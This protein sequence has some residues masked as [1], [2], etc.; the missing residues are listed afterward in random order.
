MR[1]WL[2]PADNNLQLALPGPYF[3]VGVIEFNRCYPLAFSSICW[4]VF[5]NFWSSLFFISSPAPSLNTILWLP[6]LV[7]LQDLAFSIT[8]AF[9]I[10]IWVWAFD[11]ISISF[12]RATVVSS[13][14]IP[15]FFSSA[16][17]PIIAVFTILRS[18]PFAYFFSF[19]THLKCF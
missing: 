16:I 2:G 6:W 1:R 3:S 5:F 10:H 18:I 14:I 4:L 11:F 17:F 15:V 12:H 7:Q 9:I 8:F 13:F 19:A